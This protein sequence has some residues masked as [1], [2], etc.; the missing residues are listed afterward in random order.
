[1]SRGSSPQSYPQTLWIEKKALMKPLLSGYLQVIHEVR[2]AVPEIL[3]GNENRNLT[4]KSF[5]DLTI[6]SNKMSTLLFPLGN[7]N[8]C[9]KMPL[10]NK[11]STFVFDLCTN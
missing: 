1:M 9:Q 10:H 7:W 4:V 8:Q 6:S 5:N 11:L 2:G 3:S